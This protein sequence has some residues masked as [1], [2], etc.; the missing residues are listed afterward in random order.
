MLVAGLDETIHV[1]SNGQRGAV[2]YPLSTFEYSDSVAPEGYKNLLSFSQADTFPTW[3]FGVNGILIEKK[4]WMAR[5]E[6]TTYV[7]YTLLQAPA[8]IRIDLSPFCIYRDYHWHHRGEA[9]FDVKTDLSGFTMTRAGLPATLHASASMGTFNQKP[10]WFWNFRHRM[11]ADRGLDEIEDLLVPGTFST[12]LTVGQSICL[13][14]STI[15]GALAK[16]DSARKECEQLAAN[17][18]ARIPSD[19]PHWVKTVAVTSEN[20]LVHRTI[21]PKAGTKETNDQP[22]EG[23]SVIAGFPW[24]TDWT[25]DTMIALPGLTLARGRPDQAKEVLSTFAGFVDQ[26]MLPNRF[27]DAAGELE[28]NSVDGSLLYFFALYEYYLHSKD[29]AFFVSLLPVLQQIIAAYT[30]GTRHGIYAD[31]SDGLLCSGEPGVQ[32]TWMDAKVGDWVVTPRTGKAVEINALW[33][34]ALEIAASAARLSSAKKLHAD[35]SA[36]AQTVRSSFQKFWYCEGNYLYDV[37]GSA[38]DP[39]RDAALRPNQ[40]YAVGLRFS[41][42]DDAQRK[43]VVDACTERLLTP[44]GLRSLAPDDKAY[45]GRYGGSPLDRDGVYHQGTAWAFLIGIYTR[46]FLAV[47]QDPAKALATLQ[48]LVSHL[49][50]AGVGHVSEIFDGDAPHRPNGC[51][52]QAWSSSELLYS[53]YTCVTK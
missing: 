14:F 5:R 15:P 37:I 43:A 49:T 44:V 20:F 12:P 39:T 21:R 33:Y 10:A 46:S 4:L 31:P 2:S 1:S 23:L 24:F 22:E 29:E 52:A 35:L 48:G 45:R 51:F 50:E 13:A 16:A 53:W 34:N 38:G 40:L 3:L 30:S 47:Y 7:R 25:R 19:A 32:L 6:N 11:E 28:F 8:A 27:L 41:P 17:S 9:W 42:L 18:L 36:R 26:G